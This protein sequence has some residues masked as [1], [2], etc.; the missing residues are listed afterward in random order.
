MINSCEYMSRLNIRNLTL[1]ML[2][3][4]SYF[5]CR[6]P[7]FFKINFFKIFFHKLYQNV[8][9]FG[10]RSGPTFYWSRFSKYSLTNFIRMSNKLDPDQDRHS[11]GPDLGPNSLKK[12]ISRRQKLQLAWKEL[13]NNINTLFN[14]IS[15]LCT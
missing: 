15:L 8:K 7:T 10:S 1:C 3:N 12:V 9:Q 5:C 14:L 2:G 13:T 4:I 6:L 11:V